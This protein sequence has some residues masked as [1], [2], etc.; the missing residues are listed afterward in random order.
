MPVKDKIAVQQAV[1][2][3]LEAEGVDIG[4]IWHVLHT[5]IFQHWPEPQPAC[6]VC[7]QDCCGYLR[8]WADC[9]ASSERSEHAAA[10]VPTPAVRAIN[11]TQCDFCQ[12]EAE[13]WQIGR[14]TFI[15]CQHCGGSKVYP[16][17]NLA[18]S[19]E[20]SVPQGGELAEIFRMAEA[21][22]CSDKE[23][24]DPAK[25]RTECFRCRVVR[26]VHTPPPKPDI[27]THCSV[28]G[29]PRAECEAARALSS[30]PG[31]RTKETR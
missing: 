6:E 27:L 17:P 2:A 11:R 8:G 23:E 14:F 26:M 18:V 1:S 21:A 29:H 9:K 24:C 15:G 4:R 22:E 25:P 5:E 16:R 7:G 3:G 12:Q 13:T 19:R 28:C 30:A 20:A 31:E 10:S